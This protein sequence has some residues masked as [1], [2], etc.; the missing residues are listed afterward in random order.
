[1][2]AQ[3]KNADLCKTTITASQTVDYLISQYFKAIYWMFNCS[4]VLLHLHFDSFG[5][6]KQSKEFVSV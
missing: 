5:T 2:T 3:D 4:I 6:D 1:M